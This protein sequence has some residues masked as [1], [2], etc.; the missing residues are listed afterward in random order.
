MFGAG[1]T[2]VKIKMSNILKINKLFK[3]FPVEDNV[4]GKA[5]SYLN[6]VQDVSFEVKR[7]EVFSLVGESGSGKSTIAKLICGAYNQTSGDILF[8]DKK[9][10]RTKD[11]YKRIQMVFQDPDSSLNP[12]KTVVNIIEEGLRIHRLGTKKSRREKVEKMVEAVG[13]EREV[14]KKY[15]HEL[16]GGQK[17][18]VS[19]A[20]SLILDPELVVLDEPTSALDVS[21]QAQMLNLLT[22]LQ[23]EFSL[24]Y[25]FITHDLKI[26]SQFSD[27]VAVLYLGHIMEMGSV[28]D[29]IDNPLHPYTEGLLGSVPIPDP[30][31]RSEMEVI[32]GEIPS[33]INPPEGCPF[34][35]RCNKTFDKCK[36]KPELINY[37]NRKIRCH[38]YGGIEN[39]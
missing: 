14:L 26:V 33:P 12:R 9:I 37:K 21:V 16:S 32:K 13:L 6:A 7:G 35:T 28:E 15:P 10:E 19:V 18:R 25:L 5:L 30:S 1:Y 24:T 11:N 20:R 34:I 22:D 39:A 27:T 36:T 8:N 2:K 31:A 4:F 3:R 23:H 17:Q 38:L 29:I